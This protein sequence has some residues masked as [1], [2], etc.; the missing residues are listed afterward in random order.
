MMDPIGLRFAYGNFSRSHSGIL[1][2]TRAEA[3]SVVRISFNIRKKW[4]KIKG[5]NWVRGF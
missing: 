5:K 1:F 3:G 2:M 4:W